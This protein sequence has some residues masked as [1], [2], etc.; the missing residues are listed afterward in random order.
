[1][2]L[3]LMNERELHRVGVLA[4]IRAGDRTIASGAMVLGLTAR[5]MRRLL[6]RYEQFGAPGLVHGHRSHPLNRRR[7]LAER[8]RVLA[9]VHHG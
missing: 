7:P 3:V 4:K 8:G 5:H 6:K 9:G 2:G 1:M